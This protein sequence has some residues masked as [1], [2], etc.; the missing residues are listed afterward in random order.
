M[1]VRHYS[2]VTQG[3][4]LRRSKHLRTARAFEEGRNPIA[5]AEVAGG[6]VAGVHGE[7]TLHMKGI[8]LKAYTQQRCYKAQRNSEER[9]V[10]REFSD[11]IYSI[12]DLELNC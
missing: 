12:S 7:L 8:E 2:P 11:S 10:R 9:H 5:I 3:L 6:L 1:P 4:S